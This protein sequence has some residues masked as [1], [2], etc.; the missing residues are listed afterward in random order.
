VCTQK[1]RL[2]ECTLKSSSW[3]RDDVA[4]DLRTEKANVKIRY[5]SAFKIVSV[6]FNNIASTI[7]SC[8]R[9]HSHW[10]PRPGLQQRQTSFKA[11]AT[12]SVNPV[13]A[14]LKLTK[15][16]SAP[17]AVSSSPSTVMDS[18]GDWT[19]SWDVIFLHH[20]KEEV[21]RNICFHKAKSIH[22]QSPDLIP[23]EQRTCLPRINQL[24]KHVHD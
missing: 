21:S 7:Q 8:R 20:L 17:D 14:G 19:T 10:T 4:N 22:L 18:L 9:G 3:I 13:H 2:C 15:K 11:N 23:V 1:K 12:K 5:F 16:N 6:H 24:L